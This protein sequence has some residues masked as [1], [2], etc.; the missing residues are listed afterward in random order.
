[1]DAAKRNQLSANVARR[2]NATVPQTLPVVSL[3]LAAQLSQK[4]KNIYNNIALLNIA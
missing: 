3:L 2:V 1:M 4:K